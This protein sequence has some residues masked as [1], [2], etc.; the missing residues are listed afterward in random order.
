MNLKLLMSFFIGLTLVL[1]TPLPLYA[2]GGGGNGEGRQPGDS[3]AVLGLV[4]ID[5]SASDGFSWDGEWLGGVAGGT[6]DIDNLQAYRRLTPRERA[7]ME[8]RISQADAD[9]WT[10]MGRVYGGVETIGQ[11]AA[12][13]GKVAIWGIAIGVAYPYLVPAKAV[14]V[15]KGTLV[16]LATARGAADGYAAS[17]DRGDGTEVSSAV[18]SGTVGGAVEI[19]TPGGPVVGIIVG[20]TL[21]NATTRDMRN[22]SPKPNIGDAAMRDARVTRDPYTGRPYTAPVYQ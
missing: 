8:Q 6:V 12:D 4:F 5:P 9:F 7:A 19:Y 10:T 2:C 20:E 1:T 11:Y 22:Y 3:G 13:A 14:T 16:A 17:V 18:F 15:G 21:G